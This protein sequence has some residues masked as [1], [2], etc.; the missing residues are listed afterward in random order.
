M[1]ETQLKFQHRILMAAL[2]IERFINLHKKKP[3]DRHTVCHA[4]PISILRQHLPIQFIDL[5]EKST[6]HV[7]LKQKPGAIILPVL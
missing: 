7:G 5:K 4:E 3:V 6:T 2:F 1:P